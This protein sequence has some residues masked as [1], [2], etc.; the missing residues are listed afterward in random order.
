[1]SI[2]VLIKGKEVKSPLARFFIGLWAVILSTLIGIVF[3]FVILP[4]MGV[5]LVL[6]LS[7][8]AIIVLVVLVTLLVTLAAFQYHNRNQK[9]LNKK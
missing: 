6:T 2:R 5:T 4:L 9:L 7:V 3:V 1:M 8:I